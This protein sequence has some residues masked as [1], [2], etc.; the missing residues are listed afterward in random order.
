MRPIPILLTA[1]LSLA[2]AI[3]QPPKIATVDM[4]ELFRQYHGTDEAQKQ[5][6]IERAR[7]Q[8]DNNERLA[9]IRELETALGNLRKQL[10]D[11]AVADTRKQRLFK[12]WQIQQ[13]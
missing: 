11:P 5:I 9:R 6:N 2:S 7:I 10:D 3:T 8:Q 12:D 13:Q 4:Q 1:L